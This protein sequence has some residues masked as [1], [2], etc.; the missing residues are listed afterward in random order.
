MTKDKELRIPTQLSEVTPHSLQFPSLEDLPCFKS[1]VQ[2]SWLSDQARNPEIFNALW[3]SQTF[4]KGFLHPEKLLISV[5]RD[6]EV[7]RSGEWGSHWIAAR[8]E[9]KGAAS[10]PV[11]T[12]GVKCFPLGTMSGHV[13]GMAASTQAPQWVPV[14]LDG[15]SHTKRRCHRALG[16]GGAAVGCQ[17]IMHKPCGWHN[18]VFISLTVQ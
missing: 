8:S 1:Q 12:P 2:K 4:S 15:E 10:Y 18:V 3:R 5:S 9:S 7:G 17:G 14:W 16:E 13:Q 6:L 11:L